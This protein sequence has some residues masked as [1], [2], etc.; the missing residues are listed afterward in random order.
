VDI[1][2]RRGFNPTTAE[3]VRDIACL[4]YAQISYTDLTGTTHTAQLNNVDKLYVPYSQG[5]YGL[6]RHGQEPH[7]RASTSR[8][9]DS[10]TPDWEL[11]RSVPHHGTQAMIDSI[12]SRFLAKR[13]TIPNT[14]RLHRTILNLSNQ[15]VDTQLNHV[16]HNVWRK[17]LFLHLMWL[18]KVN[19]SLDTKANTLLMLRQDH[20]DHIHLTLNMVMNAT[21]EDLDAMETPHIFEAYQKLTSAI[22]G[23][24]GIEPGLI[25]QLVDTDTGNKLSLDELAARFSIEWGEDMIALDAL[26]SD[27]YSAVMSSRV[28]LRRL[29]GNA[30]PDDFLP[31]VE[32]ALARLLTAYPGPYAGFEANREYYA[33][34]SREA[35]I[36]ISRYWLANYSNIYMM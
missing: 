32:L 14:S 13:V 27:L 9:W 12:T 36:V 11:D 2:I 8:A 33:A 6:A 7:M 23:L 10:S 28:E 24:A 20:I 29:Q 5:G 3:E 15:G 22:L 31:I 19:V 4:H 25:D 30:M 1:L 35:C 17:G 26:P 21:P 16:D 18:N 34:L